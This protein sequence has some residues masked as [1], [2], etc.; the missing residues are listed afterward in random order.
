MRYYLGMR[1]SEIAE[2]F[3]RTP[4]TIKRHLHD[5]RA[6]LR[7]LLAGLGGGLSSEPRAETR[8][9]SDSSAGVEEGNRG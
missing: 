8:G 5:G 3:G 2:E 9:L 6:R 4:G 1:E 7:A